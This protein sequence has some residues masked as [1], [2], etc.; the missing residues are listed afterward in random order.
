METT[1]SIAA[2][3]VSVIALWQSRRQSR[4]ALCPKLD[5]ACSRTVKPDGIVLAYVL[6]NNGPGPAVII[7]RYFRLNGVRQERNGHEVI[8]D[9]AQRALTGK[10]PYRIRHTSMPG[11]GT[12]LPPGQHRCIAELFLPGVSPE[13][14]ERLAPPDEITFTVEYESLQGDKYT[15]TS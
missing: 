4:I 14:E 9:Y 10:V 15:F 5:W 2:L 8:H 12:V 13:Q 7:D 6:Q 1:L 11:I 3:V